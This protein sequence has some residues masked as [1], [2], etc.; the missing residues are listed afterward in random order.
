VIAHVVLFRPRP[1]LTAADRARFNIALTTAIRGIP[2]IRRARVGR[3]LRHGAAYEA[4]MTADYEF[5]GVFEFD[6]VEGL[7][8]YLAHPE[9]AELGSLFY[10][11]NAD[12]LAYDYVV[13]DGDPTTTIAN[14]VV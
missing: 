11:M 6:D 12:A 10:T 8:A 9:H 4:L 5:I 2:S 7:R 3:R 14:F 13:P 1:D